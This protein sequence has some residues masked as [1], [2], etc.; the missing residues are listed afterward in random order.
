MKHLFSL[1][2]LLGLIWSASAEEPAR[3]TVD[4]A[5]KGHPIAKT[6]YGLFFEDINY[7][8]DGGLYAELIKNRSFDFDHPTTGWQLFGR[9][10][11]RNDGPFERNPNYM[12]LR[13]SGHRD[14]HTGIENEGFFG[15]ALKEGAEY[16]FS[17]WAR[18]E[19]E[20]DQ[21]ISLNIVSDNT[22]LEDMVIKRV[23]LSI[24]SPEWSKYEVVFTAPATL[25]KGRVRLILEQINPRQRDTEA[26]VDVEHVSLFPVDT[27]RGEKNG[28]RRDLAE[29]L[30]AL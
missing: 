23:P 17:V 11:L 18:T 1:L 19:G 15:I 21:L 25:K 13:Y 3:L 7:A 29:A 27:Y 30:A 20:G 5:A 28:L 9:V 26:T 6:M 12:R 4:A 2:A 16:R 24:T 8:A 22:E 10:E 14:I